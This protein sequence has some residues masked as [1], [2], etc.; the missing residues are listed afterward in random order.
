MGTLLLLFHAFPKHWTMYLNPAMPLYAYSQESTPKC[1]G[2]A[3][4]CNK[5]TP[6]YTLVYPCVALLCRLCSRQNRSRV[7][8]CSYALVLCI[9]KGTHSV[10]SGY[11]SQRYPD[12]SLHCDMLFILEP[13]FGCPG[14][15]LLSMLWIHTGTYS[16]VSCCSSVVHAIQTQR[17]LLFPILVQRCFMQCMQPA[18]TSQE[19]WSSFVLQPIH[20]TKSTVRY[21]GGALLHTIFKYQNLF[22]CIQ[23]QPCCMHLCTQ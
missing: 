18:A 13:A 2:A 21:P 1:P 16:H 20:T 4:T 9:H 22:S 23:V 14:A 15:P 7:A 12:A 19:Y 10:I 8:W 5:Y 11:P 17:N 6:E 3:L